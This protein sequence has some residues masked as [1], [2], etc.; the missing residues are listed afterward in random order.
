M[1]GEMLD[2]SLVTFEDTDCELSER[3]LEGTQFLQVHVKELI[4][5]P[6][7][8]ARLRDLFK[9][10]ES[11]NA[12][13][14]TSFLK[15]HRRGYS[16]GSKTYT[17]R[18]KVFMKRALDAERHNS[19]PNRLWT[20]GVNKLTDRSDEELRALLGW[21]GSAAA[22]GGDQKM[23]PSFFQVA[24]VSSIHSWGHSNK[25]PAQWSWG[26]LN[27][28]QRVH[29]QGICGSCW[30]VSATSVLQAHMEIHTPSRARP[31]SV[32]ELVSCVQNPRHCGGNGACDGATAELA[33]RY[34]MKY[35]LAST[36]TVSEAGAPQLDANTRC[37]RQTD[38]LSLLQ[39]DLSS[40]GVHQS[41]SSMIAE[42][43]SIGIKA[44]ERL[45]TNSH[46]AIMHSL[47]ERG[48]LAVAVFASRWF[49]YS[50]GIFDGCE[51]DAVIDHAVA[52]LGYGH[53][54]KLGAK[55]WLVQNSWGPEWGEGGRIRLLR[56]HSDET[57]YCGVDKQPQDGTGCD[58]GPAQV[59]V[60]GMCG[61]LYDA[62]VPHF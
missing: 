23:A 42:S 5:D 58:G 4:A 12:T 49:P 56:R 17:W 1:Q 41:S 21:S 31:L 39:E 8:G 35:G 14:F 54:R 33:M 52:L 47:V 22:A 37:P 57:D 48:P 24:S 2:G 27:A 28:S 46:G 9:Q 50:H 18:H 40:P 20:A 43:R 59:K 44:W 10:S 30:A 13:V 26:H 45:P 32:Q 51:K 55:Y 36:D 6:E 7:A 15:K 16:P 29:D 25:L 53:D 34:V 3:C 60:C 11:N 61:V 62:V 38:L 19:K